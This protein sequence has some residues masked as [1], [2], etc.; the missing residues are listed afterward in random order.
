MQDSF[1]YSDFFFSGVCLC[2]YVFTYEADLFIYL[3]I[4]LFTFYLFILLTRHQVK[5]SPSILPSFPIPL[6]LAST[7]IPPYPGTSSL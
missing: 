4:Y 7:L 3:F 5:E 2:L 6:L 1:S